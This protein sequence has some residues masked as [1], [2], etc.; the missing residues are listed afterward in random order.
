MSR[1]LITDWPTYQAATE[2]ILDLTSQKLLIFDEDLLS[3]RLHEPA[4]LN[5]LKQFLQSAQPDSARIAVR[6]AEPLRRQQSHL[7]QFFAPYAH[8]LTIHEIAEQMGSP[9]DTMILVDNQHGLIRF[10]REQARSKLLIN[11]AAE[12]RPYLQRFDEI[13]ELPGN[14]VGATNLG[15]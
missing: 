3:L 1:E 6:N 9:R 5:R 10:D 4:R 7:L 14:V 12:I 11:D 13:W 15:L 2:R 8:I